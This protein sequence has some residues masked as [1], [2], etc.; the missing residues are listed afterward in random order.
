MRNVLQGNY[1]GTDR[2]GMNGLG[3]GNDGVHVRT[4][5]TDN[6]I[7]GAAGDGN[8]ISANGKVKDGCGVYIGASG[9]VLT[10]NIV[11]LDKDKNVVAALA[12]DEGWLFVA[13]GLEDVVT[14]PNDHN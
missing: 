6:T 11:G 4:G 2:T 8:V 3:N 14:T 7:G 12:N 9:T 1:I 10:H 5:S 13:G